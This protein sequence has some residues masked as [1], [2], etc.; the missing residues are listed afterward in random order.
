MMPKAISAAFLFFL[1]PTAAFAGFSYIDPS[2]RPAAALG[3]SAVS[4]KV[5]AETVKAIDVSASA[6]VMS[7]RTLPDSGTASSAPQTFVSMPAEAPASASMPVETP[8]SVAVSAEAPID[9]SVGS[10]APVA[11]RGSAARVVMDDG[12]VVDIPP[13]SEE[14]RRAAARWEKIGG[15]TVSGDAVEKPVKKPANAKKAVEKKRKNIP[16]RTIAEKGAPAKKAAETVRPHDVRASESIGAD[17]PSLPVPGVEAS[18]LAARRPSVSVKNVMKDVPPEKETYQEVPPAPDFVLEEG[19]MRD[20]LA[21]YANEQ[22]YELSWKSPNDLVVTNRTVF[23]KGSFAGN[24]KSLFETLRRI[25]NYNLV[26]TLY[27]GNK[28]LVVEQRRSE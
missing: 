25:G 16:V 26:A 7:E 13:A 8:A 4:E 18:G 23:S 19:S 6:P 15:K 12:Y 24:V 2:G 1:V 11:D 21:K 5:P 27:N 14:E 28:V 17:A 22:G 9:T 3:E 10:A 20:Q